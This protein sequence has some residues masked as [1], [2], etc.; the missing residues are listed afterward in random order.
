MEDIPTIVVLDGFT[1]NPGDLSWDG[2]EALGD[3]AIYDRTPPELTVE[4]AAGAE[5]VL[6]NKT[7]LDRAVIGALPDL[8]YIGV[9]AT[10]FNVVDLDAAAERDIPVTNVPEY[11][12]NSVVQL[13][14]GLLIELA[15]RQAH[16]SRT[17][18]DG[19]WV[20]SPDFSYWDGSLVEIAGGTMGIVGYGR[21]GRAVARVA[22][23]FGMK[24][25]VHDVASI[26]DHAVKPVSLEDLLK[27]SDVVSLHCP[28][29]PQTSELINRDSL[30][31]MKSS[32]FLINTGRG[33]LVNEGDLADA[34][35]GGRIAGAGLDVLSTEP[36]KA[37]NPLLQAKNCIITPHIA[38][39]TFDARS[40]L[41]ETVVA[42]AA[43]FL[44][45]SPVNIVNGVDA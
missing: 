6:T 36:P 45:G 41:M 3:C 21:I 16:H 28:L 29:T 24:V 38:W 33:P 25:L 17:V 27:T 30:A 13:V 5:I 2:L 42:N 32:A 20:T 39:A 15:H 44:A 12:T 9:M 1:L 8:R 40:R 43:S 11:A 35:N 7:L 31:L 22:R 18:H 34:L 37:D 14:F 23:A 19:R 4:R 26:E 10:G